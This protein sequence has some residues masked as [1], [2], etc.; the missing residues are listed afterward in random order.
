MPS[1]DEQ[2]FPETTGRSLEELDELFE[3]HVPARKFS[4]FVTTGAGH[5]VAELEAS[6]DVSAPSQEP[7]LGQHVEGKMSDERLESHA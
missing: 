2:L 5:R 4:R 3:K 6:K 7:A 1:Y